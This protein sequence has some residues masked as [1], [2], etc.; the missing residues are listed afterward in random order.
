MSKI[1]ESMAKVHSEL[2]AIAKDQ[3][4]HGYK[5][6]GINQVLN[7]LHPLFKKY[8]IIVRREIVHWEKETK[9]YVK[10]NK[11]KMVSE[12][13]LQCKYHFTSL[14]DGS[15]L[16]SEGVGEGTD[17]SGSDKS[18][19]MAISNGFKYLIFEMFAIATEEQ[20]DS[21]Q[22]TAKEHKKEEVKEETKVRGAGYRKTA[23]VPKIET[24][25]EI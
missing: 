8:K 14:E 19:G 4:G 17:S 6:R 11:D 2:D 12:S 3:Q 18:T 20:Q 16:T 13:K 25:E 22:V 1:L 24:E 21:D 5:F 9:V 23:P 15:V 10:D 7:A